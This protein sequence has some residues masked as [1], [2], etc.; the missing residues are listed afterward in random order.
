M[1]RIVLMNI[2]NASKKLIRL[3]PDWLDQVLRPCTAVFSERFD[4]LTYTRNIIL[5]FNGN[6]K[7]Y[8]TKTKAE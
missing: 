3:W 8:I 7:L 4:Q 1:D 6:R 5:L 2:K